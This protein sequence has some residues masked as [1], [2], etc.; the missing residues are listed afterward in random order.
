MPYEEG[1]EDLKRIEGL[2]GREGASPM[3]GGP[4]AKDLSPQNLEHDRYDGR[5]WR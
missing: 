2:L 1:G 4:A 3:S 5:L